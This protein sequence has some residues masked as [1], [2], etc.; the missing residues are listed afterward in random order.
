MR[1][2]PSVCSKQTRVIALGGLAGI[3]LA[4]L[5]AVS[6]QPSPEQYAAATATLMAAQSEDRLRIL[7]VTGEAERLATREASDLMVRLTSAAAEV[8]AKQTQVAVA[9]F[10]TVSIVNATATAN[11]QMAQATA[12]AVPHQAGLAHA[13]A[14]SDVFKG[15]AVAIV[16]AAGGS[17]ALVRIAWHTGSLLKREAMTV[18]R[19][20]LGNAPVLVD[21]HQVRNPDLMVTPA[22]TSERQADWLWQLYRLWRMARAGEVLQNPG[23]TV[24]KNDEG[25]LP[26]SYA[27]LAERNAQSRTM[28]AA[29]RPE[30]NAQKKRERVRL[31]QKGQRGPAGLLG[32]PS[33]EVIA[34]TDDAARVAKEISAYLE[35]S[36]QVIDQ[37]VPVRSEPIPQGAPTEIEIAERLKGLT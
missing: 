17:V 21:G 14:T 8:Q 16:L 5:L 6:C 27:Q 3:V 2:K 15:W 29:M 26:D 1:P 11:T 20:A 34:D 13:E 7:A 18:R 35:R 22:L 12:T 10:A 25:V 23:W 32:A 4:A 19:D 33:V 37:P 31:L 30:L 36:P 24:Q 9:V 28:A